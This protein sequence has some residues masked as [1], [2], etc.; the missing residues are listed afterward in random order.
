MYLLENGE[1]QEKQQ[2]FII[3]VVFH[4][5]KPTDTAGEQ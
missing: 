1:A 4:A 3:I 5:F 2:I